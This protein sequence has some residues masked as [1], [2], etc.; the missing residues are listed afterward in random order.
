M[1]GGTGALL[2]AI[3]AANPRCSGALYDLPAVVAKSGPV[4]ARAGV[5]ERVEVIGGSFFDSVPGGC[6]RYVLQAIV[7]DWDD[8][9]C[10]RFLGNCREALAPG[11]RVLVLEQM[12]PAHDGDHFV[13]TLDLEMLVDTGKGRERTKEQFDALFA[14]AGLRVRQVCPHRHHEPVRARTRGVT[15]EAP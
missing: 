13:K 14:R 3:L 4:L 15:Y 9:S 6:D 11:G 12:M 2:A 8:D 5:A 10:V 1:G 7:H